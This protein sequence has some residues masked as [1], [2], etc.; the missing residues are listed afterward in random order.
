MPHTNMDIV[1][2]IVERKQRPNESIYDFFQLRASL[3]QPIQE[4]E[5]IKTLEANIKESIRESVFFG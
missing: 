4:Y 1:K 5:M 3:M 2:D